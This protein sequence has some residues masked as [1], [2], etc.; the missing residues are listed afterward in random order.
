M[1]R[2]STVSQ[3]SIRI[4]GKALPGAEDRQGK[5]PGFLQARLSSARV[6]CIGAG[7]LISFIAPTLARKGVGGLTLLDNDIVELS[8]L[9]RQRFYEQD[10]GKNKAF[11]LAV[12]LQPECIYNTE[13]RAY[14]L[15]FEEAV[16]DAVELTCDIAVCGVDNNPARI[17]V[18]H[19]FRERAKP[20]IFAAVSVDADH[21]Y[22]FVQKA[23][24]P[25]F[26]CLFP[27]ASST[28][29]L[30]CPGTPAI[31]DILQ[32]VGGMV[33]YAVDG[34]LMHRQMEWNYR[35]FALASAHF[36]G[37]Q[38]LPVRESCPQWHGLD[39]ANTQVKE[40]ANAST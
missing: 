29:T 39:T 14:P 2:T 30:P 22:V 36:D 23:A 38:V 37:A 17:A 15:R 25:C 19:Y 1:N 35:R 3:T 24:G 5:I 16:A 28:D 6:L 33:V 21:G 20:V 8:N 18:S 34:V 7:G 32:L 27:D 11:A 12:N 26:K 4:R 40:T 10:V 31:A 13:I 9:N